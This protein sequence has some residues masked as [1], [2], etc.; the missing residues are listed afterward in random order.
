MKR[1][2]ALTA[3]LL[4]ACET[5]SM[6]DTRKD[7][8][9]AGPPAN[10]VMVVGVSKSDANRRVFEDGFVKALAAAGVSG[11]AS[12]SAMPELGVAANDKIGPA[13]RSVGADAVMVTRVLRVNRN[14]EVRTMHAGPG[15]YG[16]GFRGY[17][18]HAY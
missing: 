18:G 3:L 9:F 11:T 7:P 14:V 16:A 4:S 8:A 1:A 6:M 13:A 5:T 2:L 17:Y 15:F 12:Y 10:K